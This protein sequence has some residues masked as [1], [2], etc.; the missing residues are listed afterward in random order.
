MPGGSFH[1]LE[2]VNNPTDA[3]DAII[4]LTDTTQQGLQQKVNLALTAYYLNQAVAL[5]LYLRPMAEKEA[6]DVSDN[7][8]PRYLYQNCGRF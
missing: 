6:Y 8:A 1:T 2:G 4:N 3:R 7:I 5:E